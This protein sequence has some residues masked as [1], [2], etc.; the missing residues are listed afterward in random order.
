MPR[1]HAGGSSFWD[2]R[3][4][5]H[6]LYTLVIAL[7]AAGGW[8]AYTHQD[9]LTYKPSP[10]TTTTTAAPRPAPPPPQGSRM[11]PAPPVRRPPAFSPPPAQPGQ[12]E[13]S[14]GG[15]ATG[16][17]APQAAQQYQNQ[18]SAPAPTQPS[19]GACPQGGGHVPGKVDANGRLHCARCGRF[20]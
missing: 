4:P 14:S 11:V 20:M 9:V 16:Y 15:Y 13:A 18:Y 8:W 7:L 6:A 17:T 2:A 19:A 10:S 5:W 3:W 1:S 12:P